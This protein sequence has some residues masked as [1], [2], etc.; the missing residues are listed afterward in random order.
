MKAQHNI[1]QDQHTGAWIAEFRLP[2]DSRW[3]TLYCGASRQEALAAYSA[4]RKA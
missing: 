2:G 4:S 3:I 1:Y